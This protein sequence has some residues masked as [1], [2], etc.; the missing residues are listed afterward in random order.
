MSP[1]RPPEIGAAKD[2]AGE[3]FLE[4][5]ERAEIA[6]LLW[7][8]PSVRADL[9]WQ[10]EVLRKAAALGTPFWRR[11]RF[12]WVVGGALTLAVAALALILVARPSSE[13]EV[14][15]RLGAQARI[16]G[17]VKVGD[18]LIVVARPRDVGDLRVFGSNH[19]LVAKCPGGAGCTAS[20]AD[21]YML[22]VVL[23]APVTY[24]VILVVGP[25]DAPGEGTMDAYLDAARAAN[26][27]IV[28][29]PE[30]NVH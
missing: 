13:L 27:R 12:R 30:I 2:A 15:I 4:E 3:R 6:E 14:T 20:T 21:R 24:H 22:E 18:R 7:S 1:R 19:T 5:D 26:A 9:R 16:H 28:R 11:A 23:A 8:M 29:Y 17:E 10:D 25:S